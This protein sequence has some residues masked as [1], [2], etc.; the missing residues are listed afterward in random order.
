MLSALARRRYRKLTGIDPFLS[1]ATQR[2]AVRL[3]PID[4]EGFDETSDLIVFQPFARTRPGRRGRAA[5]GPPS[6]RIRR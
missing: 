6:A 4:I 2:G 5:S 3:L 1:R